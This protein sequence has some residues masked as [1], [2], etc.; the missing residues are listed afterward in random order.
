MP[1]TDVPV[2]QRSGPACPAPAPRRSRPQ[3]TKRDRGGGQ[4]HQRHR[5]AARILGPGQRARAPSPSRS[6]ATSKSATQDV[7]DKVAHDRR[8]FPR[9]TEPPVDQQDRSRLAADPR[10]CRRLGPRAPKELTEIADKQI[11]QVLET[12]QDVGAVGFNGERK[13]EIQLLLDADRLNAYGLTVDQ[14]RHR[15]RSGRTSRFPAAASSPVRPRSSMRTMGRMRNVE[16]FNRIVLAYQDGSVITLRRRRR[17]CRTR[18]RKCAAQTRLDGENAVVD[19]D[20]QAVGHQHRRR[21]SIA[22]MARLDADPGD[23]AAGHHRSASSSDQSRVHP[24]VVRGHPA[25]T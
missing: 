4:H 13:R 3:I 16:D 23:A 19:V 14:V 11:K 12:V 2:G 5:R 15:G 10:R 17:A 18:T 22:C 25:C 6:S 1:K 21:S 24:Q 7:R 9:D 8:Q 20:P